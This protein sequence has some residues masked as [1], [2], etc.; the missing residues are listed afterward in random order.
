MFKTNSLYEIMQPYLHESRHLHA[1][2]RARGSGGRFLNTK[3]LQESKSS[4][5]PPF[6][7]PPHVFKNSPGKFRRGGVG[8]SGS[9]TSCS[10]ITGNNNDMF[11]QSPQFGF[12]GYPSNHHVSVLMWEG[13]G[14]WLMKSW[15]EVILGYIIDPLSF[16]LLKLLSFYN[17]CCKRSWNLSTIIFHYLFILFYVIVAEL[18]DTWFKFISFD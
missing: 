3:K 16:C 14:K 13:S 1:L 7:D 4:Q 8:S 2:K 11:Q 12:S 5:A 10:D 17:L 18:F 9:T 15:R 6:L